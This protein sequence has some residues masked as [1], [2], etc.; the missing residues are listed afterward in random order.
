MIKMCL[1]ITFVQSL[2]HGWKN[3]LGCGIE[4]MLLVM[5]WPVANLGQHCTVTHLFPA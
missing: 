2:H 5:F 3:D 4:L 1:I